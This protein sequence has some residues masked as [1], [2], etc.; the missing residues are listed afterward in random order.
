MCLPKLNDFIETVE[1]V[2]IEEVIYKLFRWRSI[3]VINLF[4]RQTMQFNCP[5]FEDIVI[6]VAPRYIAVEQRS[7][8]DRNDLKDRRT[9]RSVV[10]PEFFWILCR[11]IL[12]MRCNLDLIHRSTTLLE[13]ILYSCAE[14]A[15]KNLNSKR[16]S[17]EIRMCTC[18]S[19]PFFTLH[20]TTSHRRVLWY[21]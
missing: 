18:I 16:D 5:L 1:I 6:V 7:R 15:T 8:S 12:A 9:I 19:D 20:N 2:E 4:D 17:Y 14:C 3:W 10:M 11:L 13:T 21:V